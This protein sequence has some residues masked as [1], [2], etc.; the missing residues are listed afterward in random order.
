[1]DQIPIPRIIDRHRAGKQRPSAT[2]ALESNFRA[3]PDRLRRQL[4]T[5]ACEWLKIQLGVTHA[6]LVAMMGT[7][8]KPK[9]SRGEID[10]QTLTAMAT[11]LGDIQR[12]VRRLARNERR[13]IKATPTQPSERPTTP[14]PKPTGPGSRGSYA[15]ARLRARAAVREHDGLPVSAVASKTGLSESTLRRARRELNGGEW[16]Q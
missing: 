7:D 6:E 15:L 14:K 2:P 16:R 3:D 9:P 10:E 1:M 5:D 8:D 13:R 12:S 11:T 4:I